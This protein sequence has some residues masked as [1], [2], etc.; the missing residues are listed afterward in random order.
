ML[1]NILATS[2]SLVNMFTTILLQGFNP[3]RSV[4]FKTANSVST[5]INTVVTVLMAMLSTNSQANAKYHP[6]KDVIIL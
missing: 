4:S 2:V 3:V 6:F 1:S 5:T